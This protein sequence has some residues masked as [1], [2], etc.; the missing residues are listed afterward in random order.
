MESKKAQY[1]NGG[2]LV[3]GVRELEM[4]VR[5]RMGALGTHRWPIQVRAFQCTGNCF[6]DPWA[7]RKYFLYI[8]MRAIVLPNSSTV[9][10][11]RPDFLVESFGHLLWV[12][13]SFVSSK[14][15]Q[16][17]RAS[18]SL[19][20]RIYEHTCRRLTW[21]STVSVGRLRIQLGRVMAGSQ[22]I[23]SWSEDFRW[24]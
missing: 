2:C 10:T 24:F 13:A 9:L 17:S 5:T 19:G 4:Y 12:C 23:A 6:L 21:T 11:L 16:S 18:A 7:A 14:G 20:G 22:T 15:C 1:I 3:Q 8:E